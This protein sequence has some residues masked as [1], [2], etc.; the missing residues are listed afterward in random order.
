MIALGTTVIRAVE[1]A[2]VDGKV[3]AGT[4]FTTLKIDWQ[5]RPQVITGIITGMQVPNESHIQILEAFSDKVYEAYHIAKLD[6][7]F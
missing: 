6:G 3:M 1:S 7:F 2:V 4:A 5:F